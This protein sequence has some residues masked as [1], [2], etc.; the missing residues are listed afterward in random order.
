LPGSQFSFLLTFCQISPL[1]ELY[2]MVIGSLDA[3][4]ACV[5]KRNKQQQH[6]QPRVKEN[7]EWKAATRAAKPLPDTCLA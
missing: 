3:T 6:K 7:P 1:K 4:G 2:G 5:F